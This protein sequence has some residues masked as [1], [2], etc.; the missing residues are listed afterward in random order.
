MINRLKKIF[1]RKIKFI[2]ARN[3]LK[4]YSKTMP[5]L[6]SV[7]DSIKKLTDQGISIIEMCINET[8]LNTFIQ[9]AEYDFYYPTYYT[10]RPQVKLKKI[11]EHFVAADLLNLN[12]SDTYIDIASQY[13]PAPLVYERLFGG[14]VLRQDFDYPVGK[15]GRVLGGSAAKLE[16]ESESASKMAMHCSFEHFEGDEDL[17]FIQE[18]ER[19]LTKGG[20]LAI[21]P[22]YLCDEY[23]IRTNPYLWA[24][25]P[26][27]EWP[28]FDAEA[29]IYCPK[30]A[31][32]RHERF[33]SSDKFIQRIVQNTKMKVTIYSFGDSTSCSTGQL[34]FAAL[35]TK[36]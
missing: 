35:F 4:S 32:N 3:Y 13:S 2:T 27:N 36:I 31:A 34:R 28:R 30:D 20:S 25:L 1:F 24:S 18:A 15:H 11:K 14:T 8:K 26:N 10:N 21:V 6:F 12:K 17:L 29:K 7:E 23:F 16:V 33:Y 19:V 9:K 22:L 5:K